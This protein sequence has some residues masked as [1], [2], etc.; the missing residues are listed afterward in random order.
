M[1]VFFGCGNVSFA[2][3][4]EYWIIGHYLT[5]LTSLDIRLR[6]HTRRHTRVP[7]ICPRGSCWSRAHVLGG[8]FL[9]YFALVYFISKCTLYLF[10]VHKWLGVVYDGWN[11]CKRRTVDCAN[12]SVLL[13]TINWG[14]A[15]VPPLRSL[16]GA[17]RPVPDRRRLCG[18]L[19]GLG[20]SDVWHGWTLRLPEFQ[21]VMLYDSSTVAQIWSGIVNV[22]L[23]NAAWSVKAPILCTG[24]QE[25]FQFDWPHGKDLA[26]TTLVRR[27]AGPLLGRNLTGSR[28]IKC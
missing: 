6:R 4:G 21:K 3:F 7:M 16:H 28:S 14:N 26:I 19:L 11:S 15:F 13:T 5:I 25:A 9:W 8:R 27:T 12:G 23:P 22:R 17:I 24:D 10:T 20:L 2:L 18:G 1:T